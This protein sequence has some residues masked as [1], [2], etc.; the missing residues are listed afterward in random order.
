MDFMPIGA[1]KTDAADRC[2]VSRRT[3]KSWKAARQLDSR[4]GQNPLGDAFL[5]GN[6]LPSRGFKL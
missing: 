4:R 1:V 6:R 5:A 2:L 3:F